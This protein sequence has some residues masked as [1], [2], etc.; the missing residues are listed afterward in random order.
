MTDLMQVIKERRSIRKFEQTA[1][2]EEDLNQVLE[3]VRWAPSW[4]NCQP[5]EVIVVKDQAVNC[6]QLAFVNTQPLPQVIH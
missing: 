2:K 3:A 4:T 5:W 6:C 1:V